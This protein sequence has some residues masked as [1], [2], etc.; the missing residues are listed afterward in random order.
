MKPIDGDGGAVGGTGAPRKITRRQARITTTPETPPP[1][2]F[3]P[4]CDR[5]L[6]Y[7]ETVISG[8]KPIERWDYLDCPSCGGFV[9]RERTRKLRPAS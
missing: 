1:Q 8:V 6:A 9:Y 4:S 7:R 3:C 2:L 5:P